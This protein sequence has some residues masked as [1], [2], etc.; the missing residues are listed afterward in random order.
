MLILTRSAMGPRWKPKRDGFV[1]EPSWWPQWTAAGPRIQTHSKRFIKS[2]YTTALSTWQAGAT[3]AGMTIYLGLNP[4]GLDSIPHS[5]MTLLGDLGAGS[6]GTGKHVAGK[7]PRCYTA[8][9][10][11]SSR[12]GRRTHRGQRGRERRTLESELEA[13]DLTIAAHG[14]EGR[15]GGAVG[16][17]FYGPPSRAHFTRA[18]RDFSCEREQDADGFVDWT[19]RERLF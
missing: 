13:R 3:G 8:P 11:P 2:T 19:Y 15:Q 7:N 17:P 6:S 10:T 4:A 18:G 12:S 1:G 9:S 16:G 5:G 14:R